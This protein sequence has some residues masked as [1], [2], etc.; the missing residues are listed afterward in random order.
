MAEIKYTRVRER[1]RVGRDGGSKE[2]SWWNCLNE[3]SSDFTSNEEGEREVIF[4]VLIPVVRETTWC[5]VVAA[6]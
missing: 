2:E 5:G 4:L 6:I 3:S 1:D